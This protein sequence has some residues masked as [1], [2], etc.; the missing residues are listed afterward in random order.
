MRKYKGEILLFASAFLFAASGIPAKL[1]LAQDLTAFR[2]TQVRCLG[3][4]VLLVTFLLIRNRRSLLMTKKEIPFL[5]AYGIIGFAL[6]QS[7]YFFAIS[8][9]EL[10]I[11][12]VV[13]FTA[14]IWITFYVRY[15]QKR[16]VASTMW[17]AIALAFIGLTL[18]AQ[19]YRGMTVDGLGF[20]VALIDAFALAAYFL[21]G[22]HGVKSRSSTSL[23]TYGF[24]VATLFWFFVLPVWNFPFEIFTQ[25]IPLS[26]IS[27][28]TLPGWMLLTYMILA[29][30][31]V[32]YLCV[33]NGIRFISASQASLIGMLE[34]VIAGFFAWFAL[35]EQLAPIQI[36]GGAIVLAGIYL[37]E[38]SRQA[39]HK[40]LN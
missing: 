9:M 33:L 32:P 40:T 38:R 35:S 37:A 22:E 24:G 34:P 7:A 25:Q 39:S 31:I 30:T 29:G 36:L 23:T 15:I 8:R 20:V 3:A 4:F 17:W 21:M 27:D 10:S 6:V 2:L 19:I 26:G 5:L 18:V 28:S 1:L 13:E 11:A 12:L 14:P 16:Y